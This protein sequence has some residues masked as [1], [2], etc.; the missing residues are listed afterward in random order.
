MIKINYLMPILVNYSNEEFICFI[1]YSRD[2][3]Y[4]I[5]D[6]NENQKSE[7]TKLILLKVNNDNLVDVKTFDLNSNFKLN[8]IINEVKSESIIKKINK[9]LEE[10]KDE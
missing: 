6:L 4:F 3:V 2:N 8:K 9:S 10:N 5:N 1:D 7:L